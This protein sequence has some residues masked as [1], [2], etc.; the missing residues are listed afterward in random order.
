MRKWLV[1]GMTAV[2]ATMAVLPVA[3]ASAA[4]A[5]KHDVLTISKA[6]G[7]AVKAKAILKASLK[8]KTTATFATPQGSLVCKKSSVTE[9]V[10]KNPA[11]KGTAEL[12]LT[13]QTFTKCTLKVDGVTATVKSVKLDKLPYKITISDK[14]KGDPVT[15]SGPATTF[16]AS[17]LGMTVTCTYKAK[18]ITGSASNKKHLITFTKQSFS[19][20][21]GSNPLCP[22]SGKF[23]AAYGPVKDT[24][25]KHSPT[26][27]VS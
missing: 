20:V 1:I 27:F 9:K 10:T 15:V 12:S 7:T 5:A 26:V 4:P 18:A 23:S 2:A 22:A 6:N 19:A 11:A 8:P 24:S 17:A 25:V 16:V 14:K 21:K 13:G 3:T